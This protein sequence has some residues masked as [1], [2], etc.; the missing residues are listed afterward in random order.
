MNLRFLPQNHFH[1]TRPPLSPFSRPSSFLLPVRNAEDVQVPRKLPSLDTRYERIIE[2]DRREI[3]DRGRKGEAGETWFRSTRFI[4][5]S[6][7]YYAQCLAIKKLIVKISN[8]QLFSFQKGSPR[9]NPSPSL[10][11]IIFFVFK[12]CRTRARR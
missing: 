6:P 3:H 1:T 12:I 5:H 7:D 4:D 8:I 10:K 2:I 9:I 11:G